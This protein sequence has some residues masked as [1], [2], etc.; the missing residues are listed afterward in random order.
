MGIQNRIG[1]LVTHLIYNQN[2]NTMLVGKSC[3][4]CA[5]GELASQHT[6]KMAEFH[7]KRAFIPGCP[8]PTDSDVNKKVLFFVSGDSI[9]A[10]FIGGPPFKTEHC[11]E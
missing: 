10:F 11:S 3:R 5:A 9:F 6:C 8:S 1:Y 2:K 4:Q 7:S